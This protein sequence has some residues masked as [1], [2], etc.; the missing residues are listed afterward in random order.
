MPPARVARSKRAQQKK[1]GTAPLKKKAAFSDEHDVTAFLEDLDVEVRSRC[2]M[3][4]FEAERQA[5]AVRNAYSNELI[6]LPKNIRS[7]NVR[8]FCETYAGEIS[9]VLERDRKMVLESTGLSKS[10]GSAPSAVVLR[11][12]KAISR[13]MSMRKAQ[14]TGRKLIGPSGGLSLRNRAAMGAHTSRK[15]GNNDTGPIPL[16]TPLRGNQASSSSSSSSVFATPKFNLNNVPQTPGTVVAGGDS[17]QLTRPMKR[18]ESIMSLNG[19]PL[20][21]SSIAVSIGTDH[22]LLTDPNVASSLSGKDKDAAVSQLQ[23]LKN[24][25]ATLMESIQQS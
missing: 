14:G 21:S 23:A 3:L 10:N 18:G 6:K 7:M 17:K 4:E 13:S 5:D 24:Q 8:E 12:A 15:M 22:V 2:H 25:V 16:A 11:S 1:A 19:S 9:L 20:V